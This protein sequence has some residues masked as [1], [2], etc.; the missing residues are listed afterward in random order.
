MSDCRLNYIPDRLHWDSR[1]IKEEFNVG[2]ILYRRCEHDELE[3]PYLKISL[4]EISH[5]LGT[6]GEEVISESHD[7][8]FSIREDEQF[9]KYSDKEIATIE[10]KKLNEAGQYKKSFT[11]IK[12]GGEVTGYITLIHDPV[13]CMYPH[14]IFRIY[15]N[16]TCVGFENYRQTLQK[17][18][19][20]R[21]SIREELA[22]MLIR[23][24]L[25]QNREE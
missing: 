24:E 25:W 9:E 15:Y 2:D 11:Q 18:N 17:A 7:V 19:Q 5:N 14:S 13:S 20:I 4:V 1:P 10:I 22:F 21:T 6:C 23:K 8:L 12:N 3:N 16:D